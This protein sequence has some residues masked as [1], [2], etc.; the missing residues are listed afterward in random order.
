MSLKEIEATKNDTDRVVKVEYDFGDNLDE[1]VSRFGADVVFNRAQAAMVIDL[2][3][4]IRT[5]MS[6]SV[7]KKGETIREALSDEEIAEE[8]AKWNPGVKKIA[9]LSPKDKLKKLLAGMSE[10]D[11]AALLASA[12]AELE[13]GE[14]ED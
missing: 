10:E 7:N 14:D 9:R 6:P 1:M 12:A 13:D 5:W 8:V 4:R 11:K 2:Q 3:A